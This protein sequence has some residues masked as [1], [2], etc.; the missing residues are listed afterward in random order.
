M[1]KIINFLEFTYLSMKMNW[2]KWIFIGKWNWNFEPIAIGN[3]VHTTEYLAFRKALLL[4]AR[5]HQKIEVYIGKC[6]YNLQ[7]IWCLKGMLRPII[8]IDI[9]THSD[10]E[11]KIMLNYLKKLFFKNVL[12][13]IDHFYRYHYIHYFNYSDCMWHHVCT[14]YNSIIF[15]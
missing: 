8:C 5:L 2:K 15:T 3:S 1:D 9:N 7:K 6:I 12:A 4:L 14:I 13:F 11:W 10:K